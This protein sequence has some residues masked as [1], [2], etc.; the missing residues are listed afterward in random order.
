MKLDEKSIA[1]AIRV[2][3][4]KET[5]EIHLVFRV[6]DPKFKSYILNNWTKDIEFNIIDKLLVIKE[7]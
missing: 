5:G 4:D 2:D 3:Y 1:E 7:D 6:S